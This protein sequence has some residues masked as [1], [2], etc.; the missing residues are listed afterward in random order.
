MKGAVCAEAYFL[1]A[2][3]AIIASLLHGSQIASHRDQVQKRRQVL[4]HAVD[5]VKLTGKRGLSY[6]EDTV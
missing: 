6:R 5:I 4:E 1:R 2:S 3:K